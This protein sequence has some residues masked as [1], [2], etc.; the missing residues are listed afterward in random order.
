M[1]ID[2]ADWVIEN[3]RV[4]V[5]DAIDARVTAGEKAGALG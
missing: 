4:A 5:L 1:W 3:A 2:Y